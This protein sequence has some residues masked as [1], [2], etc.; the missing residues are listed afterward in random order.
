MKK[1]IF[2]C[3]LLLSGFSALLAQTVLTFTTSGSF[4][5]PADVTSIT[6]EAWGGGG[7]GGSA[8]GDNSPAF[9]AMGGGGGGGAYVTGIIAVTPGQVI[10]YTVAAATGLNT[11]VT[12]LDGGS[13]TFES[14]TAPG[15][16]GG[17]CVNAETNGGNIGGAGG[18]GGVGTTDGG[19]GGSSVGYAGSTTGTTAGGGGSGGTTT[20]GGAGGNWSATGGQSNGG[21]AGTTGGGAGANGRGSSGNNGLAG[22]VPGGGGSGAFAA[23]STSF[24]SGGSGAGGQ[25]RITYTVPP[26]PVTLVKFDVS[27]LSTSILLS[28]STATERNNSHFEVER[29]NDG[30]TFEKIGEVAG[31]GNSVELTNYTFEDKNPLSGVNYYRLRQVDF[32]GKFEYS[33]VRSVVF[34]STKKVTVFPAPVAAV[35]TVQL[36]EAFNNDAQWQITDMAGRLVAEGV[37]AAEQNQLAIPVNALTEGVYVLRI[38]AAQETITRQFRK[39]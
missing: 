14:V 36:D 6:V 27:T 35:M 38:V 25:I 29:S 13:S 12:P 3:V 16:Q 33:A 28:F 21:A 17:I 26:L 37:F 5:V 4:T 34:G 31:K 7:A 24:R 20:P 19:A 15:G 39:I 8:V 23:A 22:A 30:T 1:I 18:A 10:N 2:V 32:D 11:G 9:R